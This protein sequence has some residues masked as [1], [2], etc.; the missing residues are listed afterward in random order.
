M[1]FKEENRYLAIAQEII[2]TGY[3]DTSRTGTNIKKLHSCHMEFSLLDS[4]VPILSSR[5]IPFKSA[6]VEL[7][8]FI[9]GSTDIK[10]LKKHNVSIWDS[11]VKPGTHKY[12]DDF[13]AGVKELSKLGVIKPAANLNN[14][15]YLKYG[16][17]VINQVLSDLTGIDITKRK[18]IGGSIGEGAYGAQWRSWEDIRIVELEQALKL[19]KDLGY[20]IQALNGLTVEAQENNFTQASEQ[21]S[22]VTNA[23]TY[24]A[25]SKK[26]DQLQA[27][28]DLINN[29]PDSRRIIVSAWNPGKLDQASLPACHSF[30]QFL[31][32]EKD[33]V[34]YL[35][36]SLT[37]R[38][39]D[40]LVGT[41]F[42]VLQYAVLCHMVAKL[43]GRVAHKLYWQGNNTHIY[44]NQIQIFKDEHSERSPMLNKIKIVFNEQKE[45]K[46]IDD[47]TVEDITIEG[48][49]NYGEKITYPVAV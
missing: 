17:G 20:N 23:K 13:D 48:Y 7:L 14:N 38:S 28:I 8:W 49:E 40:F 1:Q 29:N 10:F 12:Q 26:Y 21:E 42:N 39:Q 6:I 2:E 19:E 30:Y 34:K 35:D 18:L 11:W 44:E 47:F 43:T 25:A 5:K 16:S 27:A 22:E 4:R 31:P 32:F 9:S 15:F 24:F 36:L 46:T 41:V 33:G 45:Y 3:E 37:C